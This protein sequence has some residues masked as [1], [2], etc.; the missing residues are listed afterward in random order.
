MIGNAAEETKRPILPVIGVGLFTLLGF[1]ELVHV[2]FVAPESGWA[3]LGPPTLWGFAF[4][5]Y[6]ESRRP[7][8]HDKRTA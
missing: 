3:W 2:L 7:Q 8:T 6:R 4:L 1:I 5:A